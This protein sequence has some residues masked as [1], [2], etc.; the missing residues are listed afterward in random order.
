M[1]TSSPMNMSERNPSTL[2]FTAVKVCKTTIATE[3][4]KEAGTS[5][6]KLLEQYEEFSSVFSEEEAHCFPPLRPCNHAINLND[7]FVLKVGKVYPLT[8]KEQKATEDFL[9]ENLQLG[10]IRPSNSPKQHSSSSLTRKMPPMPFN[11]AKT[12][13]M[14]TVILSRTHTLSLS[15]RTSLIRLKMPR[16]LPNLTFNGVQQHSYSRWRPMESGLHHP[17][18]TV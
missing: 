15:S 14:S 17:Q 2:I 12:I 11:L 13:D 6:V 8:P 7:S 4:A 3:L 1:P 9:E 5:E 16:S 18:R 10:T